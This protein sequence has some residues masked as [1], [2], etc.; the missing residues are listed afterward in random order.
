MTG[1]PVIEL[2]K[3]FWQSGLAATPRD[4]WAAIQRQLAARESWIMDGDIG[5]YDILDVR[6][7]AADTIVFLDLARALRVARHLA[8]P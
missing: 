5:P 1:L 2:D 8:L 4:Q 6:M 3:H 7:Q